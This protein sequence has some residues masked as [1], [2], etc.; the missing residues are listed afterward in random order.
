VVR[1]G[2]SD[3]MMLRWRKGCPILHKMLCTR[4]MKEKEQGANSLGTEATSMTCSES[5]RDLF[6]RVWGSGPESE[7]SFW[8]SWA[9]LSSN[10]LGNWVYRQ[11]GEWSFQEDFCVIYH[12]CTNTIMYF[13]SRCYCWIK[14]QRCAI[15][16]SPSSIAFPLLKL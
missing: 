6:V 4:K 13:L 1:G 5:S 9:S 12:N 7:E 11:I 16:Q 3:E 15:V 2:G 8:A 10:G 14:M